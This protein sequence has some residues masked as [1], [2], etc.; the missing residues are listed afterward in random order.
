MLVRHDVAHGDG[1][2]QAGQ[3]YLA[4]FRDGLLQETQ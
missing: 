2:Y 3:R 4:A 1:A